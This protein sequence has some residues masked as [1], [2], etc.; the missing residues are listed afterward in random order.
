MCYVKRLC[1][2]NYVLDY[3]LSLSS[4]LMRNDEIFFNSFDGV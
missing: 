4:G 3:D 1:K 2:K